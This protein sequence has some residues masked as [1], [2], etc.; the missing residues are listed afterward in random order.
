MLSGN[1]TPTHT[2]LHA[3]KQ[4]INIT[5]DYLTFSF[6][7]NGN[8]LLNFVTQIRCLD[9]DLCNESGAKIVVTDMTSNDQTEFVTP[10]YTFESLALPNRSSELVHAGIIDIEYKRLS[11][12]TIFL[13]HFLIYEIISCQFFMV[14]FAQ[15]LLRVQGSQSN[16]KGA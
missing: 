16:S 3:L 6:I 14:L 9:P 2:T 1:T 10:K 5:H 11:L 8:L 12:V 15:D 4:V 7:Y 13:K